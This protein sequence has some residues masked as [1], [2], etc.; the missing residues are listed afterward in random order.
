MAISFSQSK[1][2]FWRYPPTS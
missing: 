1:G 2:E